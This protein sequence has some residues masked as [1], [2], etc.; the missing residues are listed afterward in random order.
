MALQ[1][2]FRP[3]LSMRRHWHAFH[4]AWATYI[5]S[6]LNQRLPE[7]YFA[8]ANVQFGIEIDVATFEEA[9]SASPHHAAAAI[10]IDYPPPGSGVEWSVPTPTQTVPIAILTDIVEV[11]LF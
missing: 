9:G 4:K 10:D 2:H 1:D 6:A 7:G 3:P 8:E 11:L 5:S